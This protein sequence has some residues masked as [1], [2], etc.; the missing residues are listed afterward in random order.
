MMPSNPLEEAAGQSVH[1]LGAELASELG[2]TGEIAEQHV[3]WRRSPSA[4]GADAGSG[5]GAT[6]G[7]PSAAP[8]PPQNLSPGWLTNW[9]AEQRTASAA[10]QSAQKRRS[11]RFSAWHA[12]QRMAGSV[13]RG[14]RLPGV[15]LLRVR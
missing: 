4:G 10:P 2:E 15:L 7:G 6:A 13:D 12:G 8:Q 11:A 3:T 1:G 5:D 14:G 9:H